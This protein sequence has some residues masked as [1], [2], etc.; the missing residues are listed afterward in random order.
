[1]Q[2]SKLRL[3]TLLFP[4]RHPGYAVS[5]RCRKLVEEP[6]GWAK[7][8]GGLVRPKF[9]GV[10]RQGFFFTFAMAAYDL[11]RLPKLIGALAA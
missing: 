6:F 3:Q 4:P 5:Q 10:A 2:G 1:M 9:K 11:V 7:S 8:I